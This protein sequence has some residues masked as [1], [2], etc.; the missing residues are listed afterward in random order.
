MTPSPGSRSDEPGSLADRAPQNLPSG[1]ARSPDPGYRRRHQR[2]CSGRPRR[3]RHHPGQCLRLCRMAG[4]SR[5]HPPHHRVDQGEVRRSR[6]RADRGAAQRTRPGHDLPC[7]P[8]PRRIPRFGDDPAG[9]DEPRRGSGHRRDLR[10]PRPP[11]AAPLHLCLGLR[12]PG[13]P[14]AAAHPRHRQ[15]HQRCAHLDR[16]RPAVLPAR[17]DREDPA[18]DLLRRLPRHLQGPARR[19]R[20]EDPGHPLPPSA[21]LRPHRRRLGRQRRRPRLRT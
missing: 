4:G 10:R 15:D 6:A 16:R 7:R 17:R 9:V 20:P 14:P 2:L 11:L 19:R 21:R 13:L 18:G 8:R 1:G 5:R 3:R 12:R